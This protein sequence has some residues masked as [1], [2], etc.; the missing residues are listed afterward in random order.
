MKILVGIKRVIDPYAKIRVK[1]D[2]S[3]VEKSQ[4]KMSMNPFDEIAV[5]EAVRLKEKGLASEIIGVS[6]GSTACQETLR[7]GLALGLDRAILI[8]TDEEIQSL[9]VASIL[10][11]IVEQE[12]PDLIILGKQA[13][14]NDSN[15]VGQML[16]GL[17][18]WPQGTFASKLVIT[19]RKV[20]VTREVDG[21]LEVLSLQMPAVITTDL[22]LNTPRRPTLPDIMQS[23][24]KPLKVIPLIS[25]NADVAPHLKVIKISAPIPRK[26]GIKVQSASEL[27][28]KLK[29][30]A[31]VL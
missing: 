13:I 6:I 18:N 2:S 30:E 26:T 1:A 23:K 10:K 20:E 28:E 15:Q 16:A 14:D 11:K 21:G 5:E 19:D 4:V 8:E 31:H 27:I 25:L 3:G 24:Q 22:R 17:L 12:S 9:G 7:V 29:T